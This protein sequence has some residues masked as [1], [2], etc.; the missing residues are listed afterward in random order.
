MERLTYYLMW[1]GAVVLV[2]VFVYFGFGGYSIGKRSAQLE[3]Q[4]AIDAPAPRLH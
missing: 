4:L 1:A 2:T 3:A